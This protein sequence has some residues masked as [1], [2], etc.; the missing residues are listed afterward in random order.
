[1]VV[2]GLRHTIK[3][4]VHKMDA[5]KFEINQ[6]EKRDD[7]INNST[8]GLELRFLPISIFIVKTNPV[9]VYVKDFICS[10]QYKFTKTKLI[11][12]MLLKCLNMSHSSKIDSNCFK[13]FEDH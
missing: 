1:M 9:W 10:H 4:V 2:V 7:C 12:L 6:I 8:S 13:L 3:W 5:Q 11:K